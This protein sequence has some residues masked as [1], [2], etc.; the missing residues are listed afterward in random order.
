MNA[1]RALVRVGLV[2]GLV[3]A[4]RSAHAVDIAYR[5]FSDS[6]TMGPQAQEFAAKLTA[7]STTALGSESAVRFL[8]LPGIPAVPSSFGGDIATAVAA[9]AA[10]GGFD[11][12]YLSGGDI[13]KAWGFLYNSGVPFGPRFDEFVGFLYGKLANGATGL[14]MLQGILDQRQRNFVAIPIVA[15]SEQLS[16]YFPLPIGDNE[17]HVRGIG[18]AGLCQQSWTLR[19]LPPGQDVIDKACDLLVATR[20]IRAKNL[21]FIAAIPGGGSLVQ[22]VKSGQLQGFEYATPADDLSQLFNTSDNPGTVGIRYVHTPG[23]QQPFLITWMLINRDVWNRMSTAQQALLQSVARDHMMS[24]YG[25]S[26]ARQGQALRTI[27]GANHGDRDRSN[28]LVLSEWPERDQEKLI[29]AS[30]LVLDERTF[31]ESLPAADRQ[32]YATI[33]EQLRLYVRANNRYWN[34]RAV[35]PELR[36]RDW[37]SPQAEPWCDGRPG[38]RERW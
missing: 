34:L 12:A 6:A 27:L 35:K 18:L 29:Y 7:L 24:S 14:E 13:N 32:D 10:R 16:G 4:A 26:M 15:S 1:L 25:E 23:W 21:R 37:V 3:L 30:N 19:Y 36:F 28:D 2:C 22:S 9:G 17:A 38:E 5:S 20:Q 31:D 11:A 8:R 33:L